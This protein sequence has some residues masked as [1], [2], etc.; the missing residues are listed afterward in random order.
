MTLTDAGRSL[1][2]QAPELLA[3]SEAVVRRVRE[4]ARGRRHLAV[5]FGSGLSVSEAVR[6]YAL[7]QPDVE[8]SLAHLAW[9]EQAEAV[10][11][12]R[13]DVAL[14]RL[15]TG[16]PGLRVH[17]VGSEPRMVCL[18]P[19]HPLATRT[20]ISAHDLES[21]NV[22]DAQARRTST[23]E[24]KLELVAAGIGVAALPVSV[25]TSYARADVVT[26]PVPDLPP[27]PVSLVTARRPLAEH[28]RG[29][30]DLALAELPGFIG[31]TAPTG[32][33]EGSDRQ[34]AG[35]PA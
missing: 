20:S 25:T 31:S 14:V 5:G 4:S 12:G 22:L 10:R 26:R 3:A 6:G 27:V 1:L 19:T 32:R 11:D 35:V 13:V 23:V 24:E 7:A 16:T 29:F 15:P 18:P 21:E 8:V 33:D 17:L 34:P 28:V 2:D 30:V 9:Y